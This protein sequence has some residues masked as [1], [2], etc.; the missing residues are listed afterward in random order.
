MA[1]RHSGLL[2]KNINKGGSAVFVAM[3]Q[4]DCVTV[5]HFGRENK[6]I[7]PEYNIFA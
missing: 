4:I 1:A 6:C 7:Q 5:R 3:V 2:V